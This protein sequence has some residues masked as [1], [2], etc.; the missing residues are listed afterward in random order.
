MSIADIQIFVQ[1]EAY[2][3]VVSKTEEKLQRARA[4]YKRAY[5]A[6]L[7]NETSVGDQE[8]LKR[9]YLEAH[10]SYVL[11]LRATNAIV[12]RYQHHC[13]PTLL[14]EVAQVYE[15][16]SA[17]TCSCVAGISEAAG[18]RSVEQAKR[19]QT[20]AKEAQAVNALADLQLLAKNFATAATPKKPPRRL[21]VA[22]APPEQIS[23]ERINQVPALRDELVPAGMANQT[24]LE[25][26]RRE[27]DS[28]TQEIVRLQDSVDSLLRLQRKYAFS[29]LLP[30]PTW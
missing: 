29:S 23:V 18:E 13:L 10:N 4:D 9:A 22:P 16:L 2:E 25:D 5:A 19:Y 6:L 26:L 7:T 14:G 17:L 1:R 20:V 8:P 28:L 12:E 3:Q 11:Q 21:F 30:N 15:E 24:T 27:A